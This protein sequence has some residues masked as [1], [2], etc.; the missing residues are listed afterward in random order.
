MFWSAHEI[1]VK[2]GYS[3]NQVFRNWAG[4]LFF[5]TRLH[6]RSSKTQISLC[7]VI[8]RHSVGTTRSKASLCKQRKLWLDWDL[9]FI[10]Y[11]IVN[12]IYVKN[13][14]KIFAA[15]WDFPFLYMFFVSKSKLHRFVSIVFCLHDIKWICMDCIIYAYA[16]CEGPDQPAHPRSLIRAI[17]VR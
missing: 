6:V 1:G 11:S 7:R 4:E 16:D 2:P 15:F 10:M 14:Q 5:S 9:I 17:T 12:L 8:A 13:I 3:C